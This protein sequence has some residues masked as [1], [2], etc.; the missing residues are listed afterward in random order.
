MKCPYCGRGIDKKIEYVNLSIK[1][2][3]ILEFL[4]N[5]GPAGAPVKQLK[6]KFFDERSDGV[7]RTM[8]HYINKEILPNQ[9]IR[10]GGIIKLIRRD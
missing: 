10:K 6:K 5:A 3:A 1:R 7:M 9:I 8:T 2:R 4:Q